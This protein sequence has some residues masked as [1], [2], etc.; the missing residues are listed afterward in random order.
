MNEVVQAMGPDA[1]RAPA[2][3]LPADPAA[4]ASLSPELQVL[5]QEAQKRLAEWQATGR[6]LGASSLA[7][8]V[9][10]SSGLGDLDRH[11]TEIICFLTGSN[12]DFLRTIINIDTARFFRRPSQ[13]RGERRGK[14]AV[15]HQPGI[16]AQPRRNRSRQR[17]SGGTAGDP[18]ELLRRSE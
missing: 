10:C 13:T 8:A 17:R 2:G 16:A 6:G 3:P 18:N 15:T 11:D 12:E 5:K 7:D 14:P 1:L 9:V 4:D